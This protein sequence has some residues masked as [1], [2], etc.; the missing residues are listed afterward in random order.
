LVFEG[1]LT[2]IFIL[3]VICKLTTKLYLNRRNEYHI[4]KNQ[5]AVPADFASQ[6]SREDHLKAAQY[7]VTKSKFANISLI[8]N[9]AI[10]LIW[11]LGGGLNALDNFI[12]ESNIYLKAFYFLGFYT[13]ISII[14]NLPFD[15]YSTFI[16]E[17][18]FG[19]NKTTVKLYFLDQLKGL[20]LGLILGVPLFLTLIWVMEYFE[21]TWWFFGWALF[22]TFQLFI[23]LIYP[24]FIAPI[25][26]KFSPIEDENF[27]EKIKELANKINFPFKEIL[28]MNA[29]IRSSHGNAYFT[30]FG[31]QKRIVF[32]D[33]LIQ[34]L[35]DEETV[36]VLAH[37][38]G[39]FKKSHVLKRLIISFLL[40]LIGFYILFK[41]SSW[42]LFFTDHGVSTPSNLM[43]LI[44]FSKLSAT[45]TFFLTPIASYF[46]R[47]DEYE[48][49]EFAAKNSDP[50]LLISALVK[51]YKDNASTLTPD[52]LYSSFYYSHPPALERT[53]FLR[54]F[55]KK[56][57]V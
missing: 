15:L 52:P 53:K 47:K 21:N 20:A 37:E 28:V 51:M 45:Y 7:T 17:E 25:F 48:A 1:Y 39:H 31:K 23:M 57:S 33:T 43:A 14:I 27:K 40:S 18:K 34:T 54:S 6:I 29:S 32:F 12:T 26:N 30:G 56:A 35:T 46:S 44:L 11:T 10:L 16:I 22:S 50:T 41:C 36:A 4:T 5:N 24:S 55:I 9:V 49:D 2:T 42:P 13:L 38:I 19:F 8:F 3:C